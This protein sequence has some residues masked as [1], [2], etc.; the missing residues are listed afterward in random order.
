MVFKFKAFSLVAF[1]KL[2]TNTEKSYLKHLP[3]LF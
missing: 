2:P 3:F 1:M